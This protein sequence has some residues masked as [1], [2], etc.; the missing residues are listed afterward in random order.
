MGLTVEQRRERQASQ[1]LKDLKYTIPT[2]EKAYL[3]ISYKSDDWE[4]VLEE[5]VYKLQKKTGLRIYYDK[6]FDFESNEQWLIQMQKAIMSTHCKGVICFISEAYMTSY[7]ALMEILFSQTEE[8]KDRHDDKGL[9][10]FEVR[11]DL[12]TVNDIKKSILKQEQKYSVPVTMKS[13]EWDTYKNI[14]EEVVLSEEHKFR[15]AAIRLKKKPEGSLRLNDLAIIFDKILTGQSIEKNDDSYFYEALEKTIRSSSCGNEVFDDELK[16]IIIEINNHKVIEKVENIEIEEIVKQEINEINVLKVNT[17]EEKPQEVI[18]R[19]ENKLS[20]EIELENEVELDWVRWNNKLPGVEDYSLNVELFGKKE[21]G[22][23]WKNIWKKVLELIGT[24]EVYKEKFFICREKIMKNEGKDTLKTFFAGQNSNGKEYTQPYDIS[25]MGITVE[26]YWNAE[27]MCKEIKKLLK[28][29]GIDF[30]ELKIYGKLNNDS[31]NVEHVKIKPYENEGELTSG[32]NIIT[33]KLYGIEYTGNQSDFMYKVFES[34][35]P[36]HA[37]KIE[38]LEKELT[39]FSLT[40]YSSVDKEERPS[41]FRGCATFMAGGKKLCVGASYGIGDKMKQIEKMLKIC[42]EDETILEV[43]SDIG[44]SV[45]KSKTVD[46]MER[47]KKDGGKEKTQGDV[48]FVC[49]G[50]EYNRYIYSDFMAEVIK[51][52]FLQHSD[53]I[54]KVVKVLGNIVTNEK[55]EPTS[56]FR[57]SKVIE[58]NGITYYL[59]TSTGTLVKLNQIMNIM[60]VMNINPG[61]ETLTIDGETLGQAINSAKK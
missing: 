32:S 41:Y 50:K 9:E 25:S 21:Q 47:S 54:E 18:N 49:L 39:S 6:A 59:G 36:K 10:L 44:I 8:V 11:L 28:L 22:K 34:V 40:D 46:L 37:D 5:V 58:V 14:I 61:K 29:L 27:N 1:R 53:K 30:N 19:V 45:G 33:F 55:P 3:F 57:S 43:L 48:N 51:Q 35:I 60:N 13:D 56:Y 17:P 26:T 31:Q 20:S 4:K 12:D 42:G 2:D 7:A 16:E 24:E 15:D 52:L 38:I 23:I